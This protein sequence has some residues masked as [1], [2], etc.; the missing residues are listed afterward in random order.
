[1]APMEK[2]TCRG[3]FKFMIHRWVKGFDNQS[4]GFLGTHSPI[5]SS[6]AAGQQGQRG[7]K[8]RYVVHL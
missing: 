7:L 1:M 3:M 2:P 8:E 6:A 4:S 5:G